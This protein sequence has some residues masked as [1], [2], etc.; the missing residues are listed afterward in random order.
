MGKSSSMSAVISHRHM[1]SEGI[2][3]FFIKND[4]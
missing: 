2:K 3:T 1:P 4:F